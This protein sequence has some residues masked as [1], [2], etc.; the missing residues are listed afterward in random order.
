MDNSPLK[1]FAANIKFLVLFTQ[2]PLC[3]Q[4]QFKNFY[5]MPIFNLPQDFHKK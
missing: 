2:S 3:F 1:G 4:S 5:I